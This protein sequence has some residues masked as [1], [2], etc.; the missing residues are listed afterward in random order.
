MEAAAGVWVLDLLAC[1]GSGRGTGG[2]T[3]GVSCGEE[4]WWVCHFLILFLR[5]IRLGDGS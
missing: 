3:P 1:W 2:G 5:R 4:I